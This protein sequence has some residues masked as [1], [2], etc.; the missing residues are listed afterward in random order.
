MLEKAG[1]VPPRPIS[2]PAV[3]FVDLT[4]FTRL[5]EERGDQ[6]AASSA[7]QLATL[8][9]EAARRRSGRVVKLL[10][11]RA[12]L[13][14]GGAVDAVEASLDLLRRCRPQSCSR[15]TRGSTP[16]RWS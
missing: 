16:I 5:S 11:D 6:A 13:R 7:M 14:F 4:G 9:D 2:P 12:L 1:F 15:A 8:A 10:G 3:A